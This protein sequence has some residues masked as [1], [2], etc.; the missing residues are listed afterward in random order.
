MNRK[1][2]IKKLPPVIFIVVLAIWVVYNN[3]HKQTGDEEADEVS[4][5]E[6]VCVDIAECM[7]RTEMTETKEG[8]KEQLIAHVGYVT[9]WNGGW[10]EPNWVAYDLTKNEANGRG[11]RP[12]REFEPDPMVKGKSAEHRD[13]TRSGYDRGHMAPAADMKWSEQAM[14]ESFYLS[15][16]CPQATELNCGVWKRLEE[17]CR[18]L[19]EEE[20]VYICCGPIVKSTKQRIGDNGVVVPTKFFKVMCMKRKG[21][22]QAVGFVF[23]NEKCKGSMF[24]YAMS[25]DEVEKITGHDFFHN[26]PDDVELPIERNWKMKDWQ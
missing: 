10:L 17:R 23:P 15:N 3:N 21:N 6:N 20:T 12:S 18:A 19:A 9:S 8:V 26:L 13:Y 11:E 7:G 5:T 1:K 4:V 16:V 2:N 14:A 24:D 22:W 25:V